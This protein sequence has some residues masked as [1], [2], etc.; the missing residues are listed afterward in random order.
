M[1]K[2]DLEVLVQEMEELLD[3]IFE[4]SDIDSARS[5]IQD[6]WDE[7]DE[8]DVEDEGEGD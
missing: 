5:L 6:F 1:V 8:D 3:E 7:D 4:A 2:E